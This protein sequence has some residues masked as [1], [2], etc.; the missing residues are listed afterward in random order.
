MNEAILDKAA[1]IIKSVTEKKISLERIK[2]CNKLAEAG[3]DSIRIVKL[4]SVIEKEFNFEFLDD[5]LDMKNFDTLP[6]L[7]NCIEKYIC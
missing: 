1:K 3:I 4:I 6:A 2:A 7:I 5:D